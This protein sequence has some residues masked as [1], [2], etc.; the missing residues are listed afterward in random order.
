MD[1]VLLNTFQDKIQAGQEHVRKEREYYS[2]WISEINSKQ[3]RED[4]LYRWNE[5]RKSLI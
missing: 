1:S 3:Q 4:W 5:I 2:K